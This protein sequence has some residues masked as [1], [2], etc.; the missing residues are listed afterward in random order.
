MAALGEGSVGLMPG[1]ASSIDPS[2]IPLFRTVESDPEFNGTPAAQGCALSAV[3][4]WAFAL[5]HGS[6]PIPSSNAQTASRAISADAPLVPVGLIGSGK[7]GSS[8][9]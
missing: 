1:V 3:I 4:A 7:H 8:A 6:K 5:F 9:A 2:G